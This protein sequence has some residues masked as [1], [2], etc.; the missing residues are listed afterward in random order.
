[1]SKFFKILAAAFLLTS[2]FSCEEKRVLPDTSNIP[3]VRYNIDVTMHST[4]MGKE[5]K[6]NILFPKDYK[7]DTESRYPVV[8]MLKGYGE[9]G[10]D[11]TSWIS[12]I[13]TLEAN[14]VAPMIYIFPECYN[15]YYCNSYDGKNPYMDMIINE[16][17]PFV[18]KSY[19]T[20]ADRQHRAV[21]GYSMGGFGA[22]ALALKHP[23]TFSI[24]VPLSINCRKA[25]FF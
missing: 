18:D 24:S 1:M 17:V 10:K 23:E 15:S 25:D 9:A 3:F 8:Y 6:F 5:I 12:Q 20:I 4:C 13:K 7:E 22:M 14:D 21:M 16:L 2:I 19:R 11:W